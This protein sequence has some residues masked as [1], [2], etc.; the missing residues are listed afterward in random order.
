MFILILIAIVVSLFLACNRINRGSTP[1]YHVSCK[2]LGDYWN[3]ID[4]VKWDC[5]DRMDINKE[6]QHRGAAGYRDMWY[7]GNGFM[8]Q[9]FLPDQEYME[10]FLDR[11]DYPEF[12]IV[13][14]QV[15]WVRKEFYKAC[16]ERGINHIKGEHHDKPHI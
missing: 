10:V 3:R 8:D 1:R 9:S 13:S 7:I 5:R 4:R 11:D 15:K 12:D 6:T 14:K 16:K 2:D